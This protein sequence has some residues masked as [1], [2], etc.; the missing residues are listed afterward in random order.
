MA[1]VNQMMAGSGQPNRRFSFHIETNDRA[2]RITPRNVRSDPG[3]TT[4][5]W[6]IYAIRNIGLL[7]SYQRFRLWG[8]ESADSYPQAEHHPNAIQGSVKP[9]ASASS[10]EESSNGIWLAQLKAPP[11]D[12]KANEELV[13]LVAKRFKCRKS[14]VSI[15]SGAS[16]RMGWCG[17]IVTNGSLSENVAKPGSRG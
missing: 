1:T 8:Q 9:N 5:L 4:C 11:I 2:T 7:I 17:S 15:K 12:G 6:L 16:G 10:L 13:A 14:A 3:L